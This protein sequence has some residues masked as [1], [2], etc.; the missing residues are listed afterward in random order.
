[1]LI[2][3]FGLGRLDLDPHSY[4][5]LLAGWTSAA[6]G[7]TSASYGGDNEKRLERVIAERER[8]VSS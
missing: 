8:E 5:V 7:L 4:I 2:A 1:M 6:A 3:T